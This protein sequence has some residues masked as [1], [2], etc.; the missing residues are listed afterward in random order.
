MEVA[1]G[2]GRKSFVWGW[3][4]HDGVGL[5]QDCRTPPRVPC[6]V[7]AAICADSWWADREG[8]ACVCEAGS[9]EVN[10]VLLGLEAEGVIVNCSGGECYRVSE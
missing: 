2:G 3:D 10:G 9:E 7:S 6:L 4:R 8:E 5:N 1:S